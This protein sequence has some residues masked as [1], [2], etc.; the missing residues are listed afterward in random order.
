MSKPGSTQGSVSVW[1][2]ALGMVL[3]VSPLTVWWGSLEVNW[4]WPYALWAGYIALIGVMLGR[5]GRHDV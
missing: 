2:F 5:R 1:L 3:F 4:Y